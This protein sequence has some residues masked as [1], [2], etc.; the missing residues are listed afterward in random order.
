M[1]R[2]IFATKDIKSGEDFKCK[3]GYVR[4]NAHARTP[5]TRSIPRTKKNTDRYWGLWH[6][7]APTDE[8]A[9]GH[10]PGFMRTNSKEMDGF[11]IKGSP[12]CPAAIIN[13]AKDTGKL[14]NI[15]FHEAE[16]IHTVA[17]LDN[18][19]YIITV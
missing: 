6:T 11:H 15:E 17:D 9:D 1:G 2:G 8:E 10:W 4:T 16:D 3:F 18:G 5:Q 13:D 12:A 19:A 14:P 7:R